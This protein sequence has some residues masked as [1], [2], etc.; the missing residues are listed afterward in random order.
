MRL[1][2]S[3]LFVIFCSQLTLANSDSVDYVEFEKVIQEMMIELHVPGL[4]VGIV[5]KDE[6]LYM[7]GFGVRGIKSGLPVTADTQF[8]IGS[9]TKAFTATALG[10]LVD[11]NKLNWDSPIKSTYLSD[12]ELMDEY[13]T[14][15]ITTRDL[16]THR[17]GLPRHDLV[18]YG[19]P[20]SRKEIY[21]R[22]RYLEPTA[23][24]REKAQYQNMMF[25][26]AGYLNESIENT[27]WEQY[28]QEKIFTPLNMTN[29]TF[30]VE[31]MKA[32]PDFALPHRTVSG[33]PVEIPFRDIANVGPAGSINSS[34]T[35]MGQWLRLQLNQGTLGGVEVVKKKTLAE[36]HSPQIVSQILGFDK[37]Y[38]EFGTEHYAMGWFEQTYHNSRL[39][40]HGGGVDGFITF[41]GFMPKYDRGIVVFG[42]TMSMAPYFVAL[43]YFDLLIT[44]KPIPWLKRL[45]DSMKNRPRPKIVEAS[46]ILSPLDSYLGEYEHPA[47]GLVSIEKSNIPDALKFTHY[48]TVVNI[49]HYGDHGFL[50]VVAENKLIVD[51]APIQF[52]MEQNGKAGRLFYTAEPLANPIEFVRVKNKLSQFSNTLTFKSKPK[53]WIDMLKD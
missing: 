26:V 16:V 25:M 19:A 37:K 11:Q 41:V 10:T 32:S 13:A 49:G 45:K 34:V 52:A 15:L 12:F 28:I 43:S 17:S 9:T 33:K 21:D 27:T 50:S 44:G 6:A 48:S 51:M 5:S 3:T 38:S 7:K 20:L 35:D 29:S 39:L 8:A 53:T 22:L 42:N 30:N 24:I 31:Q 18:W 40:H 1:T 23:S 14:H 2:V 36:I 46:P 4:A 47:Y